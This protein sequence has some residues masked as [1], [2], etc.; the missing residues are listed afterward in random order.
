MCEPVSAG[1][2]A[3][4]MFAG[5]VTKGIADKS[6][7]DASA[8]AQRRNAII[9][10]EAASQALQKGEEDVGRIQMQGEAVKGAQRAGY[11]AAGVDVNLGSAARTQED[12]SALTEMDKQTARNNAQREAWGLEKQADNMRSSAGA[13][14]SAGWLAAG[15]D[16]IGGAAGAA[17]LFTGPRAKA[18]GK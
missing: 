18:P 14:E 12:T 6:A 4:T 17:S 16:I 8:D 10:E 1:V 15:A 9:S 11:G 13:T 7:A 3:G 5:A 2:I